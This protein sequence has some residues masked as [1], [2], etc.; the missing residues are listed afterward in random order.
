MLGGA[1]AWG[2]AAAGGA[3][4]TRLAA[5]GRGDH[6]HKLIVA[7]CSPTLPIAALPG[8]AY[9]SEP[10]GPASEERAAAQIMWRCALIVAIL[11]LG[12]ACETLQASPGRQVQWRRRCSLPACR[13]CMRRLQRSPEAQPRPLCATPQLHERHRSPRSPARALPCREPQ[14]RPALETRYHRT[15]PSPNGKERAVTRPGEA[16]MLHSCPHQRCRSSA[17]LEPSPE[18]LVELH[19]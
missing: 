3:G 7:V 2:G 11:L 1:A 8:G 14:L 18:H 12:S 4:A 19:T 17:S 15:A 6:A 10:G 5:D 16:M 13:F 9:L